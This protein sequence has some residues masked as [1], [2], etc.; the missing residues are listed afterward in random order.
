MTTFGLIA[1]GDST[2]GPRELDDDEAN[3]AR[4]S[5]GRVSPTDALTRLARC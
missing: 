1:P 3:P 2:L 4:S 5:A